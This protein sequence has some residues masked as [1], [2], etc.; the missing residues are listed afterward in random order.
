MRT[1]HLAQVLETAQ[2]NFLKLVFY[3]EN[4]VNSILKI[5]KNIN[6]LHEYDI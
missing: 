6:I 3:F 2:V 4:D 5:S 1:F